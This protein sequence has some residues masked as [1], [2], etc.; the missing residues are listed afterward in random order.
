[1]A[2][3]FRGCLIVYIEKKQNNVFVDQE[4]SA[5]INTLL[6][7]SE[8]ALRG[9]DHQHA[10]Q[11]SLLITQIAP[12]TIDAWLLRATL[13]PSLEERVACVNQLNEL[14]PGYQDRY[15]VA[16]YALKELLDEKPYLAYLEETAE[17]YRVIN[18]DRVV[19][20]IPKKRASVYPSPPEQSTATPLSPAYRWLTMSIVGLLLAGIGTVI[21]APLAVLAAIRAH[22]ASRT[23][24]EQVSS[25]V[26]LIVAFGLFM[27]GVIFSLLFLLHWFG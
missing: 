17:L 14:A 19:L 25:T 15:N 3:T 8:Q 18:A 4:P 24:T 27:L 5:Q 1:L 20:S 16:F 11:L 26:V 7:E 12:E 13:A 22:H 6:A 10:Y 23:R 9:G 21:V 2:K